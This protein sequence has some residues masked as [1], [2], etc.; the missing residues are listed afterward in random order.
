MS[1]PTLTSEE[2]IDWLYRYARR[3]YHWAVFRGIIS[4]FFFLVFVVLPVIG[5]VYLYRYAKNFDFS[6]LKN[7][8][9]QFEEFKSFD[10]SQLG[11]LLGGETQKPALP[12]R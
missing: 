6:S 5:S 3:T 2:K 4:F 10:F 11:Q 8:Q 1:K 9:S 7:I 12:K